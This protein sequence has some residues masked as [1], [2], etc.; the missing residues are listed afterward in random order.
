MSP[1]SQDEGRGPGPAVEHHD[2]LN[3]HRRQRRC[4]RPG[5][6]I[7]L[8]GLLTALLW[9]GLL[10]LLL[11]WRWDTVQGLKQ[12]EDTAALNVS[13]VSKDLERHKGDQIAQRS[14]EAQ[15]LQTVEEVQAEQ[16]RMKTQDSELSRDLDALREDLTNLKSQGLNERRT[17]LTSLERL[18]EEVS[19]LWMELRVSNGSMCNTCPE[20][21]ISFQRKCYY[22]G[23]GAKR[24]IQ[25]RY[26]CNKLNGRLV[27]I[28]NQ[29]EQDFLAKYVNKKGS[30]IGLRDLDIEGEFV[31]M[32]GSPLDYSN[33]RPGE[34]NNGGEG[35]DCV[36][37]LGLG[38]WND[39]FCNSHLEGWICDRLA[40][41]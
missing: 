14:Q 2:V 13:Q 10:T 22:F 9:A 11:L 33:W 21:W 39:A 38:Q 17:A 18:Q 4:C 6:L 19:K 12:L 26:A 36:M 34:P 35:E 7:A 5:V 23:E 16:R 41:C 40:M 3:L 25:A 27:S 28:H 1:H 32:D 31:W 15:V 30:W 29:E 37:M 24:W 8:L 20:E